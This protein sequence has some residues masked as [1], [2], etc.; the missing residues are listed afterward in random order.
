MFPPGEFEGQEANWSTNMKK[1]WQQLVEE[2]F[3]RAK[4]WDFRTC[5]GGVVE[6]VLSSCRGEKN[7]VLHKSVPSRAGA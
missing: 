1:T 4:I 7:P 2:T 3:I 5:Q 6:G